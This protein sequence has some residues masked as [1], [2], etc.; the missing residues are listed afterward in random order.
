MRTANRKE[1][2]DTV[3]EIASQVFSLN[4][5]IVDESLKTGDRE[6]WDS[7]GHIK[8]FFAL[9]KKFK[10]KFSTQDIIQTDSIEK[11]IHKVTELLL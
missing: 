7:L 5:N 9:E 2:K 8:L 1:I 3:I 4:K 11:I 10:I 6:E